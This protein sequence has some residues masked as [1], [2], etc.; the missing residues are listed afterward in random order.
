M[1]LHKKI[2]VKLY[3]EKQQKKETPRSGGLWDPSWAVEHH[4]NCGKTRGGPD[5]T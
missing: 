3:S 4:T 1:C 2:R 5:K